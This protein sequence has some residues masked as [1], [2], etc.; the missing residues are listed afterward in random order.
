[1]CQIKAYINPAVY[2][3]G[4]CDWWTKPEIV[5]WQ[6]IQLWFFI[7]VCYKKTKEGKEWGG[8][9]MYLNGLIVTSAAKMT[10][11]KRPQV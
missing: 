10:E 6:S 9:Y 5:Q 2:T 8:K 1:M 4:K 7:S 11:D 3:K